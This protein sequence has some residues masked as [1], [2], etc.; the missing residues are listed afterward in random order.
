MAVAG[1]VPSGDVTY[2]ADVDA[3]GASSTSRYIYLVQDTAN[4]IY[5]FINTTD[6]LQIING[7]TFREIAA[8]GAYSDSFKSASVM[9]RSSNTISGLLNGVETISGDAGA[10]A[11]PDQSASIRLGAA[12]STGH[13]NG[14]IKR[15]TIY[16]EAL[17][18]TEVSQL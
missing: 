5:S 6:D 10:L 18:A 15:F 8:A 13:L 1:N 2:F 4:N 3:R 7:G 14:H 16:N 11:V 17:T 12:T 9:S